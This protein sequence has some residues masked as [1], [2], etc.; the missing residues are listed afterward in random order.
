MVIN[1]DWLTSHMTLIKRNIAL[2]AISKQ[3]LASRKQNGGFE[4]VRLPNVFF[5][6]FENYRICKRRKIQSNYLFVPS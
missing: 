1:C 3:L 4:L 6:F 2:R 5:K